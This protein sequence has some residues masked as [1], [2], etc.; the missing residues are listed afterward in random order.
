MATSRGN[1]TVQG[2]ELEVL[3]DEIAALKRCLAHKDDDALF[4]E[5]M[6]NSS[7]AIVIYDEDGLLVA[8]NRNFR[9]LYG[10]SEEEARKGVHFGELG[11]IDVE[12]GNVVIGD[13]YGGGEEYLERKAEYRRKLEGSFVVHLKDGRWIRTTDRRMQRGGFVSVQVDI[14]DI[15][16]NEQALR[17]AKE[18]AE[19]AAQFKSEF[20]ANISH[21]LR[22]PLNA[23]IGFSELLMSEFKGPLGDPDYR[24]YVG[25][26]NASGHLLLSIVND[27]LDTAKLESGRLKLDCDEFDAGDCAAEVVKRLR[28]ITDR[29]QLVMKIDM[30][31]GF[32]EKVYAD[33]RATIQILNN[34]IANAAKHSEDGATIKIRL[35]NPEPGLNAISVID[36]GTGMGPELIEKVGDPFLQEGSYALHTG[37]KGAGLGLYICSKLIAALGGRMEIESKL[38]EGTTVTVIWPEDCGGPGCA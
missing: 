4:S 30:A 10:Y 22:T 16:K 26:I 9:E 31:A 36:T 28:S 33:R 13:E 2:D 25:D 17:T 23:I 1:K 18:A 15:K 27:L 6:E 19:K 8:C 37:E 3:R 7:E 35:H 20:L 34:L 32:P 21:D 29:K 12:R 38:G 11:R 24:E 5:A 14:T